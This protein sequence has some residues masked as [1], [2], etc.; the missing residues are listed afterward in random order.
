LSAESQAAQQAGV[1]FSEL[2]KLEAMRDAAKNENGGAG[3]GMGMGA[4]IGMGQMMTGAMITKEGETI[5]DKL[6]S[7]KSLFEDDLISAEE[8]KAKKKEVLGEL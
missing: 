3:L 7:L 1:N 5:S 6:K 4:G 2:Q 8:Y